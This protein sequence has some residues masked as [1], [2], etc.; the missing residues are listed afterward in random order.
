MTPRVISLQE[1]VVKGIKIMMIVKHV[2][3]LI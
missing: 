3:F 1:M 2:Y